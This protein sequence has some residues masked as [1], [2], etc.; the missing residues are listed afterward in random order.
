MNVKNS[1]ATVMVTL[2][3]SVPSITKLINLIAYCISNGPIQIIM[4]AAKDDT[5]RIANFLIAKVFRSSYIKVNFG[6]F[7]TFCSVI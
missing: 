1:Q 5:S 7:K 2:K 4:K 6:K 3:I